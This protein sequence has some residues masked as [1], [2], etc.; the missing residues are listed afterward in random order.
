MSAGKFERT[1]YEAN[2]GEIHPIRVQEETVDATFGGSANAAPAGTTTSD[3]SA[4]VSKTKREYGL[5]PRM[6]VVEFSGAAPAGYEEGNLY[7][8]PILQASTYNA[9]N[10]GNTGTYLGSSVEVVSKLPEEVR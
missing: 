1:R 3:I 10:V 5:R 8:V 2:S 9:I 4:R 7:R 6:V